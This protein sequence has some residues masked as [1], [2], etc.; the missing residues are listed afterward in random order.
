M[1][2]GQLSSD[3]VGL[4]QTLSANTVPGGSPTNGTHLGLT[5]AIPQ[6]QLKHHVALE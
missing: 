2:P 5:S 4:Q 1:A 6:L 3:L